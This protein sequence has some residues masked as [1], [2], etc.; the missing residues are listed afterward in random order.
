MSVHRHRRADAPRVRDEGSILPIVLVFLVIGSLVIL[1]L[2]TYSATVFR[3]NEVVSERT[4]ESEAAR[5]G[6]RMALADPVHT[7]DACGGA[8]LNS[9]VTLPSPGLAV[10]TTTTCYLL[11]VASARDNTSVPYSVA[12]VFVGAANPTGDG[13]V[14]TPYPGSG[15]ADE[16][17]WVADSSKLGDQ[18]TVWMP[19]LPVHSLT[20]RPSTPYDMPAGYSF[21]SFTSCHVFFPGTY[22]NPVTVSGPTY[23]TSGVYYF[24]NEVRIVANTDPSVQDTDVLAGQGTLEGCVDDQYAVFYADNAPAGH[25]VTALGATFVFGNQGRLVID[26]TDGPIRFRMNQRYVQDDDA[27]NLPTEQVSIL[28]VNGTIDAGTGDFLD[29][30][31]PGQLAVPRSLVGGTVADRLA[32]DDQYEPSILTPEAREPGAPQGILADARDK[33]VVVTWFPPATDGGS[34]ITKYRAR[35]VDGSGNPTGPFCEAT[36]LLTCAITGLPN[37]SNQRVNVVAYNDVGAGVPTPTASFTPNSTKLSIVSPGQPSNISVTESLTL[38]V[39]DQSAYV[40][41]FEV[42]WDEPASTGNGP[43]EG[44]EVEVTTPNGAGFDLYTCSTGGSRTCIVPISGGY[45]D[46]LTRTFSISVRAKNAAGWSGWY[47]ETPFMLDPVGDVYVAPTPVPNHFEPDPVVDIT[48]TTTNNLTVS[49][50]G[51]VSVPQGVVKVSMVD[52]TNKNVALAGGVLSAWTDIVDPRPA[53]FSYGL[54]NPATQRIV[55]IVTTV[56]GSII[57]SDAVVQINETG[58]WAVNSWEVQ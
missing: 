50:P 55:R 35:L 4:R 2:L 53:T 43:I 14:G 48:S 23:F 20:P 12:S 39:V 1:P 57:Q 17:A 7:Y 30:H 22:T 26:D 41:A 34:D 10:S 15:Q 37:G 28:T 24:E 27:G 40:D 49:I 13:I 21:G 38:P 47:A 36:E 5:A 52:G 32:V 29:L 42:S 11:D 46:L 51:Y 16:I 18:D 31:M 56:S 45:A 54:L 19:D 58:A 44:Y 6:L 25:N 33:G 8:G 9:G 3:A